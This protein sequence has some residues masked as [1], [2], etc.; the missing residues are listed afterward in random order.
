MIRKALE[1]IKEELQL[2][3]D[4]KDPENLR[5]AL[6][7][8]SNILDQEGKPAY[9]A[10]TSDGTNHFLVGTLVNIQEERHLR[11]PPSF[12]EIPGPELVKQN[13]DVNLNL[14]LLF[15]AFSTQYETSLRLISEVIKFFQ[16]KPYFSKSNTP[17]LD[18]EIIRIT[19][20]LNTM[21]F[22]QQNYMWGLMGAK[23]MPSVVYKLR[24]FSLADESISDKAKPIT[25]INISD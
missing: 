1:L 14:Y 8:L 16:A 12:R 3:L 15:T 10:S 13:P 7:V 18:P 19:A 20:D 11:P 6:V 25:E 24:T 4:L 22:E 9:N 2:F 17:K 5:A 21:T 23:Y